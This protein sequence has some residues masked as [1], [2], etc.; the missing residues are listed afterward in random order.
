MSTTGIELKTRHRALADAVE[1]VS[2]MRFAISMLVMIAI[3]SI[4]GTVVKQGAS[5]NEYVAQFAPFWFGLFDHLP[6]ELV[7]V[8]HVLRGDP[9]VAVRDD[10]VLAEPVVDQ[11]LEDLHLLAGDLG[12]AQPPNQLLALAAEHAAGDDF[13]PAVM[14]LFPHDVH[15]VRIVVAVSA[16]FREFGLI[17]L[18]F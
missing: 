6:H 5:L 15:G 2:S 7:G 16:D 11:R 18:F 1:L 8:A 3:A 4:I 14:G 13:D 17:E 10:V 12:A 9:H